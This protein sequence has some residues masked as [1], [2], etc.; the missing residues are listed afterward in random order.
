MARV[1]PLLGLA[2]L[3]REFDYQ[4]D[5]TQD[6]AAQ[7]GV[8]VRVRFAGR[9]VDGYLIERRET[10]D[11]P[12]K[13]GWLER[14][15][16]PEQVLTPELL[17]LSRLVADRYAGTL[18]DVLRLAIPPRHARTEQ[19]APKEPAAPIGSAPDLANWAEYTHA[20]QFVTAM[21]SGAGPRAA[22]QALPGEDWPR[23]LAE[24]ACHTVTSGK[25]AIIVVPDQRDLNRLEAACTELLGDHVVAL[26]AG[27]GPS[28]RYR[29]W[30][31][32]LRGAATVTIGTRSAIF[33][34][35]RD[36]GL[37]VVWDD[38]DESLCEP[39]APYPHTREV[40][41]L[42]AHDAS[43]ALVIGGYSRTAETQ[44]LVDSGWAHDLVAPRNTVRE[45]MGRVIALSDADERI[46][47]DR[48]ARAA[49]IPTIA[50]DTARR[51]LD[52]DRPVLVSVPR[53]GYV[54]ALACAS[55][56]QPARCRR[57]HGPLQLVAPEAHRGSAPAE[58]QCRWCGH[59]QNPF[60]C[61]DCG[62]TRARAIVVG[63]KRTAEELGR[64]FPGVAVVTSGGSTI[65]DDVPDGPRLVVATPG[66]E[67]VA[68]AGYGAALLL[69]TWAMLGRA[70]LRAAEEALRR[71]LGIVGQVRGDGTTV[72]L[73]DAGLPVVQAV[74]RF[75]PVGFAG[76]E[77]ASRAEV[78]LPPAVTMASVDG[79]VGDITDFVSMI[80][81]PE[82]MD[83]LGPVP[84]P[85]GA[86]PPAGIDAAA[87]DADV[88]RILLRINRG[89]GRELAAALRTAQVLRATSRATG[90]IRVQIDPQQIG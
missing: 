17:R 58:M 47:R 84:L 42:R 39:R 32:V 5:A 64:A 74:I 56:G 45:R 86:R 85:V 16:S 31:Q 4:V 82:G 25:S 70:D 10:T 88:Q 80:E 21:D 57:C 3:D 23:R 20:Q 46:A 89:R 26:A 53:R 68:E 73:A 55:C 61:A 40:A 28:A 59:G 8:R 72:L 35:A 52:A 18:T 78:G 30:L 54:P 37:I 51:A 50:F 81:R 22:W 44:A 87:P 7:P 9:L 66:A 48:L 38:G 71:W 79:A 14:V 60:R 2:H 76:H 19:A 90:T 65:V 41:V 34:P 33:A 63:A 43:A 62:G 12:G 13:L 36:L 27:L 69:D 24:L 77:L 83:V 11:H 75:D 49:R 15:V 1:L 67:P 6:E 29:R